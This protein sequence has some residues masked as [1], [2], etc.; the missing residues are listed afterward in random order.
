[1]T[2]WIQDLFT[3]IDYRDAKDFCGF[4]TD[5]AEFVFANAPAV[6]GKENIEA[7]VAGFFDSINGIAHDIEHVASDD[8]QVVCKGLVT[9]TRHD[10]TTLT[11]PFAN[12][13]TMQGNLIHRY[14]IFVDT[15]ELYTR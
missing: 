8:N 9:Y 11:V 15:S 4:L 13:F 7:A 1:M 14:Q 5:D 12:W 6:V 2:A 3:V 10:K